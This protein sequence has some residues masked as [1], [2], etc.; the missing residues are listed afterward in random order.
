MAL[1]GEKLASHTTL[2]KVMCIRSGRWLEETGTEGLPYKGLSCGMVTAKTSMDS[3][4]ELPS[5]FFEDTS[6]KYSGSTLL[7]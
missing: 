2:D 4:Q 6:L 5:F 1:I 3:G 7:V